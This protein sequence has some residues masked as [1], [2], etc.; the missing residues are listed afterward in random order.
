[1][2]FLL[3]LIA[4]LTLSIGHYFKML[5][6]ELLYRTYERPTRHALLNSLAIGYTVNF[7][8]PFKLGDVVRA[9]IVGRKRNIAGISLSI[10]TIIWD[11]FLDVVVV[12]FIF[13]FL[14][15]FPLTQVSDSTY[16][17]YLMLDTI[18]IVGAVSAI[19]YNKYFKILIKKFSGIFNEKIEYDFLLFFWSLISSFKEVYDKTINKTKLVVY[20][21]V[22]WVVYLGSYS[23]YAQFLTLCGNNSSFFDIFSMLFSQA[24]VG[25]STISLIEPQ[26]TYHYSLIIY[27]VTPLLLLLL[28]SAITK[29]RNTE[30]V[31]MSSDASFAK[32]LPHANHSDQREFLQIY[33]SDKQKEYITNYLAINGDVIILQDYSMGSN[34]TTMLCMNNEETFFRKFA[35]GSDG[36][37]LYEQIQ[38]IEDH[39]NILPLTRIIN[40]VNTDTYKSY[41]MEYSNNA[42][43]MF[44]YIHSTPIEQSWNILK[45]VI[46]TLKN[47]LHTRNVRP[48]DPVTATKYIESKIAANWELIINDKELKPLMKYDKLIINGKEYYNLSHFETFF[49]NEHLLEVF[50]GDVYSDIHGDMTIE[51]II[52][53]RDSAANDSSYIIDP[54]TGNV[55]DSPNLDYAKLLQS[56]HGR[57]EFLMKT[58]KVEVHDNCISYLSISSAAYSSIYKLYQAYLDEIF[59]ANKVRSI[60][61]H[62]IIHWLRL[63]PYKCRKRDKK[64]V[65]FYAGL[66]IVMND[67]MRRYEGENYDKEESRTI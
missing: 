17:Y 66:V 2:N 27:I 4:I 41:D 11:R 29:K 57:Y 13:V 59:D 25:N 49:T 8:L 6:W 19:R 45:G 54:N 20:T 34:A 60:Y 44:H 26:Y 55:H 9:Y 37:K 53:I 15:F 21:I 51:N 36:D 5:R 64:A 14:R 46:D 42:D 38:W 32:L 31:E 58:N 12:G 63:M 18:L 1:M 33:F 52:C 7:I 35:F 65:L 61:Y 47:D 28:I 39:K 30:D 50:K 43:G 40:T 23:L 56:L 62:E 48:M 10:A 22:M 16:L 3:L 24:G 67:I